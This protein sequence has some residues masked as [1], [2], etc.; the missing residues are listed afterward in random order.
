[1][2]DLIG[3]KMFESSGQLIPTPVE[4]S[5]YVTA[6]LTDNQMNSLTGFMYVSTSKQLE[7]NHFY[8]IDVDKSQQLSWTGLGAVNI[9][10]L[11]LNSYL[12]TSPWHS[13][14]ISLWSQSAFAEN[15][16]YA[17]FPTDSVEKNNS[18]IFSN[19]FLT[20]GVP[21]YIKNVE[22]FSLSLP[23][24]YIKS[25]MGLEF[26]IEP[27]YCEWSDLF[28]CVKYEQVQTKPTNHRLLLTRP[29]VST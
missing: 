18:Q 7:S 22:K 15:Y 11:F 8:V 1:M 26:T 24:F 2:L 6:N 5:A 3:R 25:F 10:V 14:T 20:S 19:P 9:D 13:S 21:A 12:N 23:T 27:K 17:G 29:P 4:K 28:V 16:I